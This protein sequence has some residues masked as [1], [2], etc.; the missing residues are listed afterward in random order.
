MQIGE[1]EQGG[2][3]T[4]VVESDGGS[5]DWRGGTPG[6]PDRLPGCPIL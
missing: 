5:G 6:L 3:T 1:K 4:M 2:V